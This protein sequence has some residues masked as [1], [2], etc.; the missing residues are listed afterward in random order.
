MKV[1]GGKASELRIH[2]WGV[3]MICQCNRLYYS[4]DAWNMYC[5]LFLCLVL[6]FLGDNMVSAALT[7]SQDLARSRSE[8]ATRADARV[9]GGSGEN[10]R[11]L[12]HE[13]G[14]VGHQSSWYCSKKSK[15][16]PN[17]CRCA[18]RRVMCTT[19]ERQLIASLRTSSVMPPS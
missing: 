5:F 12:E 10:M 7:T 1:S 19:A 17:P 13:L 16:S 18:Q 9:R 11:S 2:L 4:W 6:R 14:R 3:I 8:V 15:S